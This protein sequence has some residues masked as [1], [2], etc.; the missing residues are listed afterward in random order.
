MALEPLDPDE[1]HQSLGLR[2]DAMAPGATHRIGD[3][4]CGCARLRV[5]RR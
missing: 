3:R 1:V 2:A 5:I 4:C